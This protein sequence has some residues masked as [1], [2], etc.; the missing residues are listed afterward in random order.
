MM[1]RDPEA[2]MSYLP[3]P[4]RRVDEILADIIA[5]A[6]REAEQR[7]RPKHKESTTRSDDDQDAMQGPGGDE[8][9]KEA[10]ACKALADAVGRALMLVE[11][12]TKGRSNAATIATTRDEQDGIDRNDLNATNVGRRRSSRDAQDD[13]EDSAGAVEADARDEVDNGANQKQLESAASAAKKKKKTNKLVDIGA[14]LT[15][16]PPALVDEDDGGGNYGATQTRG[17]LMS[18]KELIASEGN[19]MY[20]L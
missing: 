7:E 9:S 8:A 13:S 14:L 20:T 12:R 15:Y 11:E 18:W 6:L 1:M 17:A 5:N 3:Q 2:Y 19:F 10:M 4:F 16:L